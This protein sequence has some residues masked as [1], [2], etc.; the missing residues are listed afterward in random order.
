MPQKERAVGT[1]LAVRRPRSQQAMERSHNAVAYAV[2]LLTVLFF[3]GPLLWLTSMSF[4]GPAEVF[5]YPPRWIPARLSLQNYWFVLRSTQVPLFLMN[6]FKVA[7]VSTGLILLVA[8]PAAFGFSRFRFR[9]KTAALMSIMAFQ[10]ISPIVIVVPIYKLM[11]SLGLHD[12]HLGLIL[13]YVGIQVPFSV[14]LLKGFF[15]T[16]PRSLDESALIDGCNRLTA[17][18]YVLLPVALPG[19]AAAVIFNFV[20][21]WSEFIMALITLNSQE[22]LTLS[23]GIFNFQSGY[24]TQWHLIAATALLGILPVI[25][26]YV[27]LQRFFIAGLTAGAIKG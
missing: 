6:S 22:L 15:D 21:A 7:L 3:I 19:L 24:G 17:L 2:F 14:W 27:L 5:A 23:I 13:L 8:V 20:F 18:L 26:L 4:K 25:I 11:L 16:I 10:M 1:A 9:G 12:T